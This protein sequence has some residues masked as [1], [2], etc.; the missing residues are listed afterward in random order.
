M[1][2]LQ[3]EI[4]DRNEILL[5]DLIECAFILRGVL[6]D[7]KDSPI[8]KTAFSKIIANYLLDQKAKKFIKWEPHPFGAI[9]VIPAKD[10]IRFNQDIYLF[11]DAISELKLWKYEKKGSRGFFTMSEAQKSAA[12]EWIQDYER[13]YMLRG[14]SQ[15]YGGFSTIELNQ[16]CF[17][18]T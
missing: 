8:T 2:I 12:E 6:N 15:L 5:E 1:S 18:S 4:G 13:K 16:L 11:S 17:L 3:G 14:Y 9:A 7:N 10:G